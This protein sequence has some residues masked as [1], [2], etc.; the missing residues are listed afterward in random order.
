MPATTRWPAGRA[1]TRSTAARGND[2]LDGGSGN[3]VLL[4]GTG[5][6]TLDGGSGN[7]T[8]DGQTGEDQL[9]GGTGDDTLVVHSIHDLALETPFGADGGGIDTIV[10]TDDYTASLKHE[11]PQLAPHGLATFALG[12]T[13]GDPL[14]D[15]VNAYRQQVQPDIENVRLE[16]TSAHDVV[17]DGRANTIVGND[18][19]NMLFGGGG[20]DHV[21]GGAGTDHIDG[22][23]GND[24]LSGGAG[25][26]LVYGGAGDDVFVIGLHEDG[27]DTIF[28]HEG[29]NALKVDAG[30]GDLLAAHLNGSDLVL[31]DNGADV[32][33]VKDYAGNPGAF[34]GVDT[35]HGVTSLDDLL[36][37]HVA[38]APADILGPFLDGTGT[39]QAAQATQAA[40]PLPAASEAAASAPSAGMA[41]EAAFMTAHDLWLPPDSSD[42]VVIED[43]A[44][45]SGQAAEQD[46]HHAHKV[47]A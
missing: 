23:A 39:A 2:A 46:H 38:D 30:D 32:A 16:G 4:G 29:V 42:L 37:P 17:G 47:M 45:K 15:G 27:T 18:G 33:I 22:G 1:T 44:P 14:P 8:L 34:S 36:A 21:E 43:P 25:D 10:V 41:G 20:D 40:A 31:T 19:D 12:Q 13:L 5:N 11:L 6:D 26:D 9:H 35:G 7:D 3:D 28:D 24:W